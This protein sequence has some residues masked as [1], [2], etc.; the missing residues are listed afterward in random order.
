MSSLKMC[1]PAREG[2]TLVEHTIIEMAKGILANAGTKV[3]N[4]KPAEVA[5]QAMQMTD[6]LF[7]ELAAH[8]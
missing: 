3:T 5:S 1:S 8:V 2:M 4:L 6:A 7:A